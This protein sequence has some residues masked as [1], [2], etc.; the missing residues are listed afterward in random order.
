MLL[1]RIEARTLPEAL[2]KVRAECG[3]DAL[4]VETKQTPRGYLVVAARP[5]ATPPRI[6]APTQS[7]LLSR[8]TRGFQPLA[9]AATAFGLPDAV[10]RAVEKALLGTRVELSQPG[11]PALPGLAARTLAGLLRRENRVEDADPAFRTVALV[12]PTGV[13]KTTTLAKLAARAKDRGERVAVLTLDTYR[14]AAVEQ[15]RAYADLLATPFEVCFTATDLRRALQ[16]HADKDRI[17]VDTTGRSPRDRDALP[18]L[19]GNLRAGQCATLLCLAAGTRAADARLVLDA[20]EPLG[21]DA[22]CLTKW[23][24]TTAPGEALGAVVERGLPLSHVCVGQEVPQDILAA[25]PMALAEAAF[26]L[27]GAGAAR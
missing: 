15:L 19:E 2:A 14:M 27:Q 12:G 18:L 26:D 17:F 5:E 3:E 10:L 23:D 6:A 11:D 1:K 22:V 8:W 7:G 9:D 24:E 20:F 4:L 13:G 25:E 21:V 16:Q